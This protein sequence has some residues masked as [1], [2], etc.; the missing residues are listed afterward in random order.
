MRPQPARVELYNMNGIRVISAEWNGQREYTLS[1]A[2]MPPGLYFLHV[3]F[4]NAA[5]T[6][7]LIK[8]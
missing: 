4:G 2:A 3:V 6:V 8:L 5:E 1:I 7:K